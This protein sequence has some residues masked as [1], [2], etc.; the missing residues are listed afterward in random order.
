MR[1]NNHRRR[2]YN[3]CKVT[4]CYQLC[5]SATREGGTSC[6]RLI[7]HPSDVFCCGRDRRTEPRDVETYGLASH[8]FPQYFL[9]KPNSITIIARR[10]PI[11][12]ISRAL[13][14][15]NSNNND[16]YKLKFSSKELL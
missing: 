5:A 14:L 12:S 4:I 2:K 3:K 8:A 10:I 9:I 15:L 16:L 1:C 11:N 13:Y 6:E 7:E